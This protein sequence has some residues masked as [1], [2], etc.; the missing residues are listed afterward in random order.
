MNNADYKLEHSMI[1]ESMQRW[2]RDEW[3]ARLKRPVTSNPVCVT[4]EC[5]QQLPGSLDCGAF[6]YMFIKHSVLHSPLLVRES[7]T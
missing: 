2:W 1:I 5:P 7:S 4:Q 3:D 6:M